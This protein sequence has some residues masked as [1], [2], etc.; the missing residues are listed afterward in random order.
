MIKL[1]QHFPLLFTFIIAFITM[2]WASVH[3]HLAESH[4]HDEI[5]YHEL[6]G[7]AHNLTTPHSDTIEPF[8]LA[9]DFNT[10]DLDNQLNPPPGKHNT[11]D[12]ATVPS[13]F[14]QYTRVQTVRF[15]RP[16]TDNLFYHRLERSVANPRAP[17]YFS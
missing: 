6:E 17:P 3:I 5:H 8:H 1:R 9:N 15:E 11:P 16:L 10:I 4:T 14:Q 13:Y 7:H 12:Q 2:Q